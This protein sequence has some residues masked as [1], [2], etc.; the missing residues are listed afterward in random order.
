MPA[1]IEICPVQLP[2]RE[3]RMGEKP[4]RHITPLLDAL[5]EVL[6]PELDRPFAFFGHSM[7]AAIAY[8]LAHRWLRD[9]GETPEH[10]LVSGRRPLTLPRLRGP[11]HEL[12]HDGFIA[13]LREYQG[14]PGAVSRT[15]S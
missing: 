3:G 2:G 15:P 8:K 14:T 11:D 6:R 1:E 12:P 5:T 13:R 4:F 9:L 7:G 10:L